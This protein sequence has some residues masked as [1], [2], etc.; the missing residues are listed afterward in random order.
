[1]FK[2]EQLE[3]ILFLDIETASN[4]AGYEAMSERMQALWD[5]KSKRY[6]RDY[7]EPTDSA[8]IYRDKAAIHAEFGRV[9]CI[10]CGY[11]RFGEDGNA[12]LKMRSFWGEDEQKLLADFADNVNKFCSRPGRLLAAHNGKEFD[13]PYLGRRYLINGLAV[14]YVLR[15]QGKKPWETAFVDT[16]EL[17]KFGDFKSYT[18]LETLAAIFDVPT[19]KDD[20]DGSQVSSA[21]YDGQ[22]ERIKT[23]CEKDVVV[24]AQVM[25]RLC[26]HAGHVSVVSS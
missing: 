2:Q 4:V 21:Y 8:T 18:S 15:V 23:Y 22:V 7:D 19:S 12:V 25:L 3:N 11:L 16:M 24:T 20:I 13:F 26:G 5:K 14:P 17:W 6:E 1:M 10:S 9:V